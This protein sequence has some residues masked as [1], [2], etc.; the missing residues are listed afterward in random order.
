M[1]A[2]VLDTGPIV[3][4]LNTTDRRHRDCARLLTSMAGRRLLPRPVLTEVCWLLERWPDVE[5]AFLDETARGAFELIHLA[6]A[7]LTRMAELVRHYADFPLGAVDASVL[8]VAERFGADRVATLDHR[9]FGAVKP[10][11]VPAL[12]LVP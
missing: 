6:P 4:A 11:H 1:I 3:A 5:A 10:A 7:D 9:H 8:A 2:T 12:T